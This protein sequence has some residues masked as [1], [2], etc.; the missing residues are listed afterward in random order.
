MM[1][2]TYSPELIKNGT[3]R[4]GDRLSILQPVIKLADNVKLQ[5]K[6]CYLDSLKSK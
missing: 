6:E 2:E 3:V 4:K 1:I 5:I